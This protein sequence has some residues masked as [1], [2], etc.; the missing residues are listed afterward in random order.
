MSC[1]RRT[2]NDGWSVEPV[3]ESLCGVLDAR[4]PGSIHHDLIRAGII[5]HPDEPGGEAAQAWV[6]RTA[7]CWR[8][9]IEEESFPRTVVF[10]SIDTVATIRFNGEVIGCARNQFH[11][12]RFELPP[13]E[14]VLE[15]EI[16]A[17]LEELDRLVHA[18]GDRPVN[19][20]GAWGV[21]SYLRKSACS[22]GWDWGPMCPGAGLLGSV[23]L[24]TSC[25]PRIESVRPLVRRCSAARAEVEVHLEL[26]GEGE[27]EISLSAPDGSAIE[28]VNGQAVIDSPELWWP[29]GL[30]DQPLY[31]LDVVLRED[32]E[33]VD[34][35]QRTIGLRHVQL[36]TD[37][38]EFAFEINGVRVFAR[39][40]N[41]IPEGVFPGTASPELIIERIEQAFDANMNMLRVWGGG[42]YEHDVFYETCDR[43]GIMVWQDF[44]FACAT[45]PEEPPF[46][47]L[48]ESEVRYQVSRLASH[49][50]IVLWCG[51]NENILAWRNWGWK[52]KMAPE[53][54]WGKLYFTEL[55]PRICEELDPTR[56]FLADSPYSGSVQ[57]DPNDPEVGDRH[58]WDIK[59]EAIRSLV[60]RFVSEFGHQAP[61]SI[62]TIREAIGPPSLGALQ[63][64]QRAW[65][66]DKS[67][68]HDHLEQ[69]FDPAESEEG[70]IMQTHVLQ[71]RAT[72]IAFEWL[73]ANS[74]RCAGA[75]IWQLNDAWVGHSW[76]LIDVAGR[77]KPAYWAARRAC[78]DRLLSIQPF[79]EVLHVVAINDTLEEWRGLVTVNRVSFTGEVLG[80]ETVELAVERGEVM[81]WAL[82]ESVARA[83]DPTSECIRA[84]ISGQQSTYFFAPDKA[85]QLPLP[86]FESSV[87]NSG[88][89]VVRAKTL[90]K[91]VLLADSGAGVE[92]FITLFPG[93]KMRI[94]CS[95]DRAEGLV[96]SGVLRVAPGYGS[97]EA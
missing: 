23:T 24:E 76:S 33:E 3:G 29:R 20:D 70:T 67:E 16:A 32:G 61:P 66:G 64:R 30:G 10:E 26:H 42:V 85:L 68:Y 55:L 87:E 8:R 81:R 38:G 79:E 46:P 52:E 22:F 54:T 90:L 69:W 48:V 56:P 47:S 15:V 75:L 77:P 53:Q 83:G 7:F 72:S 84:S 82:S 97:I 44:M 80:E 17:P 43:L 86:A 36:M 2:I 40:A 41:W 57:A 93:E 63:E 11:P 58:T 4:V 31:M 39:G 45:Y 13:G 27:V 1:L 73:R 50:S 71:A 28:V 18:Y 19:A 35:V 88:E 95:I 62:A 96:S 78:A 59:L 65:G 91:D 49:P 34:R 9:T 6:G 14:G 5:P 12:H 60:P 94:T 89:V 21:Y 37:K 51:G 74:P 92:E 25:M